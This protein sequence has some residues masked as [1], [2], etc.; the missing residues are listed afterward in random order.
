M[1]NAYV[2][3]LASLSIMIGS[4]QA[5][6]GAAPAA[7]AVGPWFATALPAPLSDPTKPVMK[8]DDTFAPFAAK[9]P[10]AAGQHDELLDGAELKAAMKIIVGFS[11][12]SYAAG[13]KVW[14]RRSA[15][16]AFS[17]AIEWA[18][19]QF[20]TAGIADSKVERFPVTVPMW[21]PRSWSVQLIGD[22]AFG[23]GS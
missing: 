2:L 22:D 7:P 13:D 18:V 6:R 3:L 4:A 21:T 16:P 17:H 23:A 20:K 19:E 11:L 5:R 8:Y 12:E 10:H 9:F 15:T 14:G 1:R